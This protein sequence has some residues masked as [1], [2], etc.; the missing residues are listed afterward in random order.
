MAGRALFPAM[1]RP[2][3]HPMTHEELS[4]ALRALDAPYLIDADGRT[5]LL[6]TEFPATT[7]D[8]RRVTVTRLDPALVAGLTD[9]DAFLDV[10]GNRQHRAVRDAGGTIGAGITPAGVVFVVH[11]GSREGESLAER[12][13][14]DGTVSS[15]ELRAI[16]D[17][18]A[19]QLLHEHSASLVHGL[20]YPETIRLGPDGRVTLGWSGLLSALRAGGLSAPEIGRRLRC[21]SYLAPEVLSGAAESVASDIYAVGATLYEAMTGR[22]PFGGRTTATVMAA[23]LSDDVTS[24]PDSASEVLTTTVLRAIEREPIDRWHD[25]G[26]FRAALVAADKPV[27]GSRARSPRRRQGKVIALLVLGAGAV[28]LWRVF[29]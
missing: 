11:G 3:I 27:P 10:F 16:A 20:V 2:S 19:T 29:R 1:F 12:L 26:Q 13:R 28:V 24:Q 5:S 9:V 22:P 6:G 15:S 18:V 21:T 17:Q 8:G 4:R 14:R 23:V 25:A 7:A